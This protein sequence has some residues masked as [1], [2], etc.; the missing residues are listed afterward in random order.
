MLLKILS[1]TIAHHVSPPFPQSCRWSLVLE[2]PPRQC[3]ELRDYVVIHRNGDKHDRDL[4]VE[5]AAVHV[6][7]QCRYMY[8][9]VLLSCDVIDDNQA[10]GSVPV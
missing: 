6:E 10:D 1:L 3:P 7:Y 4:Y 2:S 9:T 5:S 8:R